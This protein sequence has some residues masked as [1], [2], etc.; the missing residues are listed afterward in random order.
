M[1]REQ[2]NVSKNSNNAH[3]MY[4]RSLDSGVLSFMHFHEALEILYLTKGSIKCT[5]ANSEFVMFPGDILF[6]NSN[7]PHA[8]DCL[9]DGTNCALFQFLNPTEVDSRLSYLT[10]FLNVSDVATHIFKPKDPDY[11]E[12]CSCLNRMIER[13]TDTSTEYNCYITSDIYILM[14]ILHR[15]RFLIDDYLTVKTELLNKIS[16]VFQFIDENYAEHLALEDLAKSVS[17]HK[18]YFCRLFKQATG[19]T[20][21][22]YLNFVRVCKA[23]Q[24]LKHNHNITDIAYQV[25]FASASYFTK[26]FRKYRLCS[27]STY[28]RIYEN[29]DMIFHDKLINEKRILF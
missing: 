29:P 12:F 18:E 20:A 10:E 14:A 28:R 13:P 7:I 24:L 4:S 23:E 21:I 19:S 17:F 2:L 1:K 6:V 26:I 11:E 3:I 16:P 9:E 25:G 27:P 15:R 5:L 22:D 8:T